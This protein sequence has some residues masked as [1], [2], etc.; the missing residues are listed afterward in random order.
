MRLFLLY[1]GSA[2]ALYL[3]WRL[4]LLTATLAFAY[5]ERLWPG[6]LPGGR[7]APPNCRLCLWLL[8]AGILVSG[9]S[10]SSQDP[11]Q[12]REIQGDWSDVELLYRRQHA[13]LDISRKDFCRTYGVRRCEQGRR[14]G[15]VGCLER[16][17]M[18]RCLK[19]AP[20]FTPV[21]G[22][23]LSQR[24]PNVNDP[25]EINLAWPLNKLRARLSWAS[26][27]TKNDE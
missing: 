14:D 3:A 20:P 9:T 12:L 11:L 6:F 17:H 10:S 23:V 24:S 19:L 8:I 15:E 18:N 1:V 16:P 26:E 21:V 27:N 13:P 7:P 4:T 25:L 5:L 2:A 22:D